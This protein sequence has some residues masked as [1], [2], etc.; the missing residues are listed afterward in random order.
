MNNNKLE[1]LSVILTNRC[2][3]KCIYCGRNENKDLSCIKDELSN[4]EWLEIF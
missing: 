2:N 4:E 1:I 3:L